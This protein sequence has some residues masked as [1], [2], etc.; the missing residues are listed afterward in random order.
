MI[1][2]PSDLVLRML[3]SF[4]FVRFFPR[5]IPRLAAVGGAG[6]GVGGLNRSGAL[7]DCAGLGVGRDSIPAQRRFGGVA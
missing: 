7:G 2:R 5:L 4:A 1:V 6:R 3:M